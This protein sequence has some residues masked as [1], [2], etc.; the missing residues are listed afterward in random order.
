M[1][2]FIHALEHCHTKLIKSDQYHRRVQEEEHDAERWRPLS[3]E[4]G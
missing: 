4:V 1:I 3:G 2:E